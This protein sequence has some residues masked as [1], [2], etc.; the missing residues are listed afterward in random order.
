MR[1]DLYVFIYHF[2]PLC[3]NFL[4][5]YSETSVQSRGSVPITALETSVNH[6][7]LSASQDCGHSS[8]CLRRWCRIVRRIPAG[9]DFWQCRRASH[10]FRKADAQIMYT[11]HVQPQLSV[12]QENHQTYFDALFCQLVEFIKDW[13]GLNRRGRLQQLK[14]SHFCHIS[15]PFTRVE[16]FRR[17]VRWPWAVP[18]VVCSAVRAC[19]KGEG[20]CWKSLWSG[21]IVTGWQQFSSDG[22]TSAEL[23]I[24]TQRIRNQ[25]PW[26]RT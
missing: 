21:S 15:C 17:H 18:P 3:V 23:T 2:I 14:H 11:G 19:L 4:L 26:H 5:I 24:S 10:Y 1:R 22:V 8:Q 20:P 9:R 25:C 6:C 12:T 13:S 7:D 16:L